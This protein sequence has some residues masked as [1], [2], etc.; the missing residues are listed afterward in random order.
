MVLRCARELR[1]NMI[2]KYQND[3]FTLT[4]LRLIGQIYV[5]SFVKYVF[6]W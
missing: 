1:Y 2:Q 3:C 6:S 5:A 4:K